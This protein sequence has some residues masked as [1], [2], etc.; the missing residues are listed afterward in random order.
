MPSLSDAVALI[1]MLA[2]A[3]KVAPL[4]GEVIE[5]LGGLL[6]G[7]PPPVSSQSS[8][9]THPPLDSMPTSIDPLVTLMPEIV[10]CVQPDA[11]VLRFVLSCEPP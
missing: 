3:V 8:K 10:R 1:V 7:V 4:T 11:A 2:P 6:A 9:F 5:A